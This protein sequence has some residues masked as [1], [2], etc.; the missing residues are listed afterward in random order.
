VASRPRP[1]KIVPTATL[2][3]SPPRASVGTG[4]IHPGAD[5]TDEEREFMVAMDRYKRV[6]RR[7]YP[8]WR[9][10][11]SVLRDLGYRQARAGTVEG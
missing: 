3:T 5:Y 6:N 2:R 11:L 8:S 10:V 9:E 4:Q 7:P 1:P